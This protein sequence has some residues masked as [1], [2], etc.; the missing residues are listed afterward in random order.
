M[1]G[2]KFFNLGST[3]SSVGVDAPALLGPACLTSVPLLHTHMYAHN[4]HKLMEHI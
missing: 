2:S 1:R 3:S 4:E